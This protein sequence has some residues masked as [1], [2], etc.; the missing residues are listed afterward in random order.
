MLKEQATNRVGA[1][2]VPRYAMATAA[3]EIRIPA[4]P[5]RRA[6]RTYAAPPI[7]APAPQLA[8]I[9]AYP[10]GPAWRERVA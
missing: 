5:A 10:A 9:A 3:V 6:R 2:P 1:R 4:W 7:T 8:R